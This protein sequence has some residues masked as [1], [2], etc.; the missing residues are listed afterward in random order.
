MSIRPEIVSLTATDLLYWFESGALEL[1]PKFQRRS[2]WT[3]NAKSFFIDSLLAGYPIPPL[4]IRRRNKQK[5]STVALEVIDGQQRLRALF[6]FLTGQLVLGSN[7]DVAWANRS[8]EMLSNEQRASV[9][10]AHFVVYEYSELEDS[11]VLE[12]FARLNTYAV[13]LNSQELRNGK[14]FGP[15]KETVYELAP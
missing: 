11:Q 13:G 5:G 1:S 15:F 8:I 12:I 10:N 14:Y 9:F 2:V 3:R 6:D 4:H 7:V